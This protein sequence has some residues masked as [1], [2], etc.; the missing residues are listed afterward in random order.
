VRTEAEVVARAERQLRLIML[1][2]TAWNPQ[3]S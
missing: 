3:R 1:G 2:M